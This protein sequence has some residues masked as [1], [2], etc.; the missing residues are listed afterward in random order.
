MPPWSRGPRAPGDDDSDEEERFRPAVFETERQRS[1]EKDGDR[2]EWWRWI[3]SV[4]A[5]FNSSVNSDTAVVS[6]D[7]VANG[8]SSCRVV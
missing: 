3:V 8:F 5:H 7:F 2:D 1:P 6:S 4:Q